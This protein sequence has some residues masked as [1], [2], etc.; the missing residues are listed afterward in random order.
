MLTDFIGGKPGDF[1]RMGRL[2][3]RD[4]LGQSYRVRRATIRGLGGRRRGRLFRQ[5]QFVEFRAC[6]LRVG[7]VWMSTQEGPPSFGRLCPLGDPIVQVLVDIRCG[8]WID[9]ENARFWLRGRKGVVVDDVN[10]I[11][12]S[13][14]A[15]STF[16]GA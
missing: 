1:R 2:A 3:R 10:V 12:P 11:K 16:S 4:D 13:D 5:S 8:D 15:T 9:R 7:A 14:L 6:K